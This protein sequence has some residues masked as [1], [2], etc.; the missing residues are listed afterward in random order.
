MPSADRRNRSVSR[1]FDYIDVEGMDGKTAEVSMML[2]SGDLMTVRA[3]GYGIHSRPA[4][5]PF[6]TYEVLTDGEPPR[7]WH[8]YSEATGVLFAH[9]PKLLIAHQIARHG[10][11]QWMDAEA[12]ERKPPASQ[13][14]SLRLKMPPEKEHDVLMVLRS[15]IGVDVLG[16]RIVHPDALQM[17]V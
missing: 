14:M 5:G 9:V 6:E 12:V 10:G 17:G 7:F 15:M 4:C 8:R 3:G 13:T 2:V 11:I 16:S 1:V